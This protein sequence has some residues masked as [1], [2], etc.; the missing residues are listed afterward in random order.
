MFELISDSNLLTK[1]VMKNQIQ[2]YKQCIGFEHFTHML[3]KRGCT[4]DN[5]KEVKHLITNEFLDQLN[6][7]LY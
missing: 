6:L 3:K 5:I 1:L 2:A 7:T 4:E